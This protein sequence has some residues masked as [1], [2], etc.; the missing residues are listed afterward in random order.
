MYCA[1]LTI[2]SL[3]TFILFR[4]KNKLFKRI[5]LLKLEFE[6]IKNV[7]GK[8]MVI[9]KKNYFY[10]GKIIVYNFNHEII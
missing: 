9:E 8:N 6:I 4:T 1:P 10:N 3:H 5:V 2:I 7:K